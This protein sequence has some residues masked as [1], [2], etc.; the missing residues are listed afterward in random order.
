MATSS[1]K[2]STKQAQ[3]QT[4]IRS[5]DSEE[6]SQ[7]VKLAVADAIKDAIPKFVEDVVEQ[8]SAKTQAMVAEQISEFRS[9]MLTIRA[10]TSKCMGDMETSKS[11]LTEVDSRLT[12]SV[13]KLTVLCAT[14]EN[15]VADFEDR[16][17]RDNV[18]MHGVPENPETTNPLASLSD[19]IPTWFPEL[20]SVEIMCAHRQGRMPT[21]SLSHVLLCSWALLGRQR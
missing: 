4:N 9:E 19:T 6:L 7:L 14:L 16:S 18:R 15:K 21:E 17:R 10:D 12:A 8:L 2:Q 5:V 13:D 11:C 20:G 1:R 3:V